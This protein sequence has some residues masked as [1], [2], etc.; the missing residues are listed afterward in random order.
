MNSCQDVRTTWWE[1]RGFEP[2]AIAG[3]GRLDLLLSSPINAQPARGPRLLDHPRPYIWRF[4]ELPGKMIAALTAAQAFYRIRSAA[5]STNAKGS[6]RPRATRRST[7]TFTMAT[8]SGVCEALSGFCD[9]A[10][11][12]ILGSRC[13][14]NARKQSEREVAPDVT[15]TA[16]L[17][18]ASG[19]VMCGRIWALSDKI[20]TDAPRYA[21]GATGIA[22][23]DQAMT[24]RHSASAAERLCL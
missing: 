22:S 17:R 3:A 1:L 9:T 8:R 5:V 14:R 7:R 11:R 13:H 6:Q 24:V 20:G 19:F 12:W 16:R 18:P 23:E 21:F 15:L 2:M 10:I 4:D